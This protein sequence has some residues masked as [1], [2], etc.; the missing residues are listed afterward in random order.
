MSLFDE[1]APTKSVSGSVPAG[2]GSG[3]DSKKPGLDSEACARPWTVAEL[4]DWAT[5]H[6][7]LGGHS[8]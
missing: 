1:S 3:S 6:A 2:T 4:L 7:G 8:S 5:Y